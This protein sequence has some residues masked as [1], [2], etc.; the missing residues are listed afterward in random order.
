M[1]EKEFIPG[2]VATGQEP[3]VKLKED[4]FRLTIRKKFCAIK[5]TRPQKKLSRGVVEAHGPWPMAHP[6]KHSQ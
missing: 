3:M 2:S 5:V 1:M 6:W 4:R